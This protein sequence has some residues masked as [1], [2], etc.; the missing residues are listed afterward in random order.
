MSQFEL[1]LVLSLCRNYYNSNSAFNKDVGELIY[2]QKILIVTSTLPVSDSD[3]V[4]SFVRDQSIWLKKIR[5]ELKIDILAPHNS[6]SQT[7]NFNAHKYYDEHRF[8]YFWPSRFEQLSGRG[9]LPA[10]KKNK[11]LYAQIP[12]LFLFQFFALLRIT[13]KLNPDLIYAH[14]FTPQGINAAM[15]AMITKT[16][17]IFTTHASDVSVLSKVPFSKMLVHKVCNKARAFTAVSERTAIKLKSYF[18]EN[19]WKNFQSKFSILPMGVDTDMPSISSSQIEK[20]KLKHNIAVNKKY[21][22]FM[23]RLAEKKGVTYLLDAWSQID[24]SLS[25]KIHLIIAGDGQLN[26][27]LQEQANTL[28]LNNV[29]FTGY[30]HGED[31][32]LL[33]AL[34]DYL[35]LPSI[36]DSS[37]DSEG[38]PVVLMEGLAAGKIILASN[39]SGGESI[40]KD[41]INGFIFRE[42]SSTELKEVL[43]KALKLDNKQTDKISG[44]SKK[45]ALQY[46]WDT[47]AKKHYEI[48]DK[49]ISENTINK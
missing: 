32:D 21:V 5:P 9:I 15:V 28:N 14:W 31:K 23:G 42:K 10:L 19:E 20:I 3:P 43:Q 36:V 1:P 4:P 24:D 22:L 2:M 18:S 37:G 16:P 49:V 33:L 48:I 7:E 34:A 41:G 12:F 30:I 6:Y 35:C 44:L 46:R 40:L 11:I 13:R 17:F 47:I 26:K 38:F 8:H 39:T 45:L 27:V 29:T 25:S